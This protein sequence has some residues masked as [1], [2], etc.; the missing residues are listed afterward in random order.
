MKFL[1]VAVNE[2]RTVVFT[3]SF[4]FGLL[5]PPILYGGMF[6]LMFVVKGVSDLSERKLVIVD[7]SDVL[8]PAFEEAVVKY[9]RG[10]K[11]FDDEGEQ[12][13]PTFGVERYVG[14]VTE[15]DELELALSDRVRSDDAF[16]FLIIGA[17]FPK[18][19]GGEADF[20]KYY[21]NSPTAMEMP[22][23]INETIREAVESLRLDAAGLDERSIRQIFSH[24]KLERFNLAVKAADGSVEKPKK[25]N[26]ILSVFTPMVIAMMLFFGVQIA[27]PIL[28][29][30][31]IEEKMQRIAE[32]LL[33]SV[34][35]TQLLWGKILAGTAVALTFSAAY[36]ATG[37]LALFQLE[38]LDYVSAELFV[39]FFL[40][41]IVSL[42]TFGSLLAGISASCQDL[43]DSQNMAGSVMILMVI[44]LM[45]SMSIL[46]AP[47]SGLAQ[48]L[49]FIPPFSPMVMCVRMAIP[50]GVDAWE[51]LVALL[52][53]AV[54][55]VIVVFGAARVFRIG[56]LAQGKT[57]SWKQL[58][59]WALRG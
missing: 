15:L 47:E 17:D 40:F 29:S 58:M 35:P 32:V 37:T 54:F 7:Q 41:L 18:V 52:I 50:P 8:Y 57:P 49:S 9:N 2:Y 12:I 1:T 51:P 5:L 43:K 36:M 44:P 25:E 38:R 4:L 3:K 56:I 27:S 34:T 6:L 30:S 46:G 11:V 42:L 39:Y 16:A 28:L 45:A 33:S 22:N 48:T 23:W 13:S 24:N 20:I 26:Q 31:V 14:E 59:R 53:N 10:D 19:E 21:S 55:A